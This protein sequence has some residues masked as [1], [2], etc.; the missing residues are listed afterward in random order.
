MRHNYCELENCASPDKQAFSHCCKCSRFAC[1]ECYHAFTKTEIDKAAGVLHVCNEC[2]HEIVYHSMEK[3]HDLELEIDEYEEDLDRE[4]ESL[5][6]L[7]NLIGRRDRVDYT[8]AAIER[9]AGD[10][11]EKISK[12]RTEIERLKNF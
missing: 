2:F 11:E 4:H 8:I 10:L 7:R 3:I 5:N 9:K 6:E 12:A 1:S